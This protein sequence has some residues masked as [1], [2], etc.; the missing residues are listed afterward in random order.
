MSTYVHAMFLLR[1]SRN[2]DSVWR[3]CIWLVSR[4]N[5][6]HRYDVKAGGRR[7]FLCVLFVHRVRLLKKTHN[8]NLFDPYEKTIS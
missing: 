1:T 6:E 4:E 2:V 8:N 7:Y 3:T 5:P